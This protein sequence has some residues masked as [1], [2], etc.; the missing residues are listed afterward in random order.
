[1][2]HSDQFKAGEQAQA[3]T[4]HCPFKQ[5]AAR[6]IRV[7]RWCR[8]IHVRLSKVQDALL[9]RRLSNNLTFPRGDGAVA[10]KAVNFNR[11]LRVAALAKV[12]RIGLSRRQKIGRSLTLLIA[13][14]AIDTKFQTIIGSFYLTLLN[15]WVPLR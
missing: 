5:A 1:M 10:L 11:H 6:G 13:R 7:I 3:Y 8:F 12:L 14:M 4:G 2:S 9:V 15:A